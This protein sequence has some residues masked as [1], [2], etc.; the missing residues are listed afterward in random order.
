MG[1]KIDQ[2]NNRANKD[3]NGF[4]TENNRMY[5]TVG[6]FQPITRDTNNNRV[7]YDFWWTN[8]TLMRDLFSSTNMAAMTSRE[9]YLYYY[10]ANEM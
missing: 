5:D 2:K 10:A 4:S 9:N 8:K 6:R 3:N 7:T 1:F